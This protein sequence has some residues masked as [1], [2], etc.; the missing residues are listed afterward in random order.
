[1]GRWQ[2]GRAQP[3]HGLCQPGEVGVWASPPFRLHTCLSVPPSQQPAPLPLPVPLKLPITPDGPAVN[4]PPSAI[5]R[6]I[7][8]FATPWGDR[9]IDSRKVL[10]CKGSC[11]LIIMINSS[12]LPGSVSYITLWAPLEEI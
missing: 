2:G 3:A 6:Q 5:R 4:G 11:S 1:M 10:P 8:L 12:L 9:G 7:N